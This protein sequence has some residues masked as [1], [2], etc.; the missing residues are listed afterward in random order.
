MSQ[1]TVNWSCYQLQ[2]CK[3]TPH[4]ALWSCQ[5]QGYASRCHVYCQKWIYIPPAPSARTWRDVFKFKF[6]IVN[7]PRNFFSPAVRGVSNPWYFSWV[8]QKKHPRETPT[9]ENGLTCAL[10]MKCVFVLKPHIFDQQVL[11]YFSVALLKPGATLKWLQSISC[12]WEA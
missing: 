2:R 7:T 12:R 4:F 3:Q 5:A 6:K 1:T 11:F 8:F 9:I 10:Q